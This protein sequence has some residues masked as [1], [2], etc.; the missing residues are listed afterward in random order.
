MAAVQ[1]VDFHKLST[2][3]KVKTLPDGPE[4][5]AKS[6]WDQTGAV[7]QIVRR[8]GWKFCREEAQWLSSKASQLGAVKLHAIVKED[9]DNE[10]EE[11]REFFTGDIHLDEKKEF[12]GP[13]ERVGG[14]SD[15]M[16]FK[17]MGA[18]RKIQTTGNMKGEGWVMGGVLVVGP[19]EQG[20]L[21]QHIEAKVAERCD[22]DKVMEA[23]QKIGQ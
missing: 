10:I 23:V 16:S 11:F 12:Y 13:H 1:G 2:E 3:T 22:I 17:M 21:Y 18:Y 6:L 5:T 20:I 8:P 7:I 15:L 4:V 14:M 9:L 19:G